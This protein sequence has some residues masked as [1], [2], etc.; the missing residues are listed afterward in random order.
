M[1]APP[2]DSSARSKLE[3]KVDK[4]SNRLQMLEPFKKWSGDDIKDAAVL[5][6]VSNHRG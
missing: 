5:I 1:Q 2:T 4:A 6:K 3:V